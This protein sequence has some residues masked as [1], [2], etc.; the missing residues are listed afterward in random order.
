M[1]RQ[2]TRAFVLGLADYRETS[3]L[4][5]LLSDSH[6]RLSVV[7]RGLANPKRKAALPEP[8]VLVQ[9]VF[10]LREGADLGTLASLEVERVFRAPRGSVEA[11]ALVSY[12]FDV[13][14]AM[15]MPGPG[16]GGLF[17][18]TEGFM[19]SLDAGGVWAAEVWWHLGRLLAAAGVE[20]RF[21]RCAGCG[22]RGGVTH[23]HV[24]RGEALCPRCVSDA[25]EVL[26]LQG[27]APGRLGAALTGPHRPDRTLTVPARAAETF[28]AFFHSMSA[29]H[30]GISSRSH[31]FLCD[32][33]F[34]WR[35]RR[36]RR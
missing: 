26:P 3:K 8:F 31:A 10:S 16:G 22:A 34:P 25:E 24:A 5:K 2:Q 13:V 27:L 21:D 32:A 29:F 4:L 6:G 17:E 7:A 36:P 1:S 15:A 23:V 28:V 9:A 30:L 18:L 33:L 35:G 11:Y 19:E 20:V 12:W 14:G